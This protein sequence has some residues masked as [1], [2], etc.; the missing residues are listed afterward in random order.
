MYAFFFNHFYG[1]MTFDKKAHT[2]T[3]THHKIKQ[4]SRLNL[5]ENHINTDAIEGKLQKSIACAVWNKKKTRKRSLLPGQC[6]EQPT[7]IHTHA[8][9]PQHYAL[10]SIILIARLKSVDDT[11]EHIPTYKFQT[12]RIQIISNNSAHETRFGCHILCTDRLC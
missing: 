10:Q 9:H 12:T 1:C 5:R 3:R 2:C 7:N 11:K 4:K 6:N 8:L